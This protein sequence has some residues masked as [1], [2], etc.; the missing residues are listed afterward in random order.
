MVTYNLQPLIYLQ[1]QAKF[2]LPG[3]STALH[4]YTSLVGKYKPMRY[5]HSRDAVT[6]LRTQPA[7]SAYLR[8]L[9]PTMRT[10]K[11]EAIHLPGQ[12]HY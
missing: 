10:P 11:G 4:T 3:N 7:I 6:S 5:P 1:T 8:H 9:D 2:N 12:F